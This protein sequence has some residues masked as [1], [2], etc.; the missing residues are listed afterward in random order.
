M[1]T[2]HILSY[3]MVDGPT[4]PRCGDPVQPRRHAAQRVLRPLPPARVSAARRRRTAA[5]PAG[6]AGFLPANIAPSNPRLRG[7]PSGTRFTFAADPVPIYAP[8]TSQNHHHGIFPAKHYI[9]SG[10]KHRF[11]RRRE[12]WARRA[13]R[14][15]P[16]FSVASATPWHVFPQTRRRQRHFACRSQ[17]HDTIAPLQAAAPTASL[18]ARS[19]ASSSRPTTCRLYA[20]TP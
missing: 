8:L 20:R 1:T 15:E 13:G 2:Y 14:H 11:L 6:S 19:R 16:V 4:G 9:V 5:A 10:R 18:R 12:R 7:K 17:Y 3:L